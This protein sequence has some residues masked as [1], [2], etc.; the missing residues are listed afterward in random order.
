MREE[1]NEKALEEVVGGTV[2]IS[3]DYMNVGF[4]TTREK[5]DLK[6]CT[7]RQVRNFIDDLLD[8]N[9]N[10]SNAAFDKLAKEKLQ[11]KGWI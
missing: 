6:N 5:F 7:Y 11:A 10:L 2:I 4:S 9:P 3:K 8:E 1:L